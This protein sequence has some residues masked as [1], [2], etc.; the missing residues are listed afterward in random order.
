M[1][2]QQKLAEA[3]EEIISMLRQC[4]EDKKIKMPIFM[5]FNNIAFVNNNYIQL[6][7]GKIKPYSD[8][9]KSLIPNEARP[10]FIT[11]EDKYAGFIFETEYEY[12]IDYKNQKNLSSET[13]E[14]FKIIQN[15]QE[16][17]CLTFVLALEENPQ[18]SVNHT[19]TIIFDPLSYGSSISWTHSKNPYNPQR[20]LQTRYQEQIQK[21]AKIIKISN[22]KSIR[23]AIRRTLSAINDR[24]NRTDSFIDFITA[25][26]NLFGGRFDISFRI[27]VS[28]AKILKESEKD[29]SD[30]Q[31]KIKKYYNLRSNIVHG[32][33]CNNDE[34]IKAY[35]D[36]ILITLNIL[37]KLYEKHSNLFEIKESSKRSET[38]AL[39]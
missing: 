22:D 11:S 7:W 2:S 5:G 24:T 23:I 35:D 33:E 27:S 30:E 16:N 26:E 19:W 29:R 31:A 12:E 32:G 4:A 18:L 15:I 6:E 34:I 14:I 17:I 25:W 37:R 13:N 1:I 20:I 10:R 36:C 8:E 39:W 21:W 3:V 38:I 28:I 9:V